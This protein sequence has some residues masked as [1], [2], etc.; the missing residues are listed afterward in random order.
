MR[1][2]IY[3]VAREDVQDVHHASVVISAYG[4]VILGICIPHDARALRGLLG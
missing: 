1:V 3:C 2:K 4:M